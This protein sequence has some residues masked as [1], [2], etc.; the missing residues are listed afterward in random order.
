M[1]IAAPPIRL[2]EPRPGG[3]GAVP[4]ERALRAAGTVLLGL[5]IALIGFDLLQPSPY[6][7]L[8]GPVILVWLVIGVRLPRNAF[9]LMALLLL[10][11][12]GVFL[13]LVPHLDRPD[14]VFWAAISLYLAVTAVFFAMLFADDT[15]RRVELALRAFL[16]SCLVAASAGIAGY[17]DVL[18][19]ASLFT[20]MGRASGTFEDPN[21][22]GSFLIL[23]ILFVLRDLLTGAGR[24]P[25][26][27]FVLLPI[28]LGGVLLAFS[29]GAWAATM[30]A[31]LALLA[32]TFASN[33]SAR[34][35][36]RIVGIT[37][38]AGLVG[39]ASIVALLATDAVR[40]MIEVRAQVVQ[41]YDSGET[42]RFGIQLRS[43]PLLVERPNGFG[44]LRYRAWFGAEP[45]NT[46]L[47]AF[48]SGGWIGGFAFI[49]LMLATTYVGLRLSMTPS[50]YQRHAQIFF[51]THLTFILQSFQIDIDHW[52]H[53]Y[54]VWGALWGLEAARL[55]WLCAG[56]AVRIEAT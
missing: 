45:H 44:P 1:T 2:T 33:R 27:G 6:D 52:R 12:L 18:G 14:S 41:D 55:R 13:S 3:I 54:L 23:G 5:F 28:L 22:F 20:A 37:I 46:Y 26:L 16:A 56:R 40:E 25:W 8:A 21:V 39:A 50:P 49:G 53:V 42:G 19:T 34:V 38:A 11:C 10:L 32:M 4:A 51:A 31:G 30:L 35:R 24:R 15:E 36:R 9:L 43:I 17:F 7:F 48:G 29:R 47:N